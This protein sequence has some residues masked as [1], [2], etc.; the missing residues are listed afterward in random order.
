MYTLVLTEPDLWNEEAN[1]FVIGKQHVFKLEHSLI[2]M[3]LWETE[4]ERSFYYDPPKTVPEMIYYIRCMTIKPEFKDEYVKYITV[5][6]INEVNEYIGRK[7][8]AS[9]PR[10]DEG[11]KRYGKPRKEYITTEQIYSWMVAYR[12]PFE[13]AKWPFNRLWNLIQF[14][15]GQNKKPRK[16]TA[17]ERAAIVKANRAKLGTK[18]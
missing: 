14:C 18:G 12:I 9:R 2:S 7:M 1:E 10:K 6:T 17:K 3:S 16:T 8:S 5:H 13:T 15:E 4:Y 11:P